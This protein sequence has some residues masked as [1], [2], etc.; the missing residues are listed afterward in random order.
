MDNDDC[1]LLRCGVKSVSGPFEAGRDGAAPARRALGGA[2]PLPRRRAE[3]DLS[4]D[5][6]HVI[7][8]VGAHA[9]SPS[10]SISVDGQRSVAV[11]ESPCTR[12][13]SHQSIDLSP[14]IWHWIGPGIGAAQSVSGGGTTDAGPIRPSLIGFS[15]PPGAMEAGS[16]RLSFEKNEVLACRANGR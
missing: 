12:P 9:P 16:A 10:L 8:R 13:A 11:A 4:P 3:A 14:L 5:L 15:V 1:E 2:G 6:A 7:R